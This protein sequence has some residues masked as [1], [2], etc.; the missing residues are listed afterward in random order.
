[1]KDGSLGRTRTCDPEIN[2]L[3][4]YQLSYQGISKKIQT[5][6]LYESAKWCQAILGVY[7][8]KVRAVTSWI[9]RTFY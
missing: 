4:L 8:V 1:M 6:S 3:L 5:L 2:S 7:A 9:L